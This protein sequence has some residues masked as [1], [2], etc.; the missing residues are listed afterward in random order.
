MKHQPNPMLETQFSLG[1]EGKRILEAAGIDGITLE[2]K[3]PKQWLHFKAINDNYGH[4]IG[5][6]VIKFVADI[7]ESNCREQELVSCRFSQR[8]INL[9]EEVD[10]YLQDGYCAPVAL[11]IFNG[12]SNAVEEL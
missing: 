8:V 11:R 4:G 3:P 9:L 1:S 10:A 7:I 12:L 6:D 5:D 2:K